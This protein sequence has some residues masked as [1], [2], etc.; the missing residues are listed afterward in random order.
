MTVSPDRAAPGL[1][2]LT[3]Q[4]GLSE[5]GWTGEDFGLVV[6]SFIYPQGHDF[7]SSPHFLASG[8]GALKASPMGV[9]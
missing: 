5:A 4:N 2:V 6:H 7:W 1:A 8:F 9:Q 3:A